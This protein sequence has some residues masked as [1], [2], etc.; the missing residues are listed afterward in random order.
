M[1]PSFTFQVTAYAFDHWMAPK[2]VFTITVTRAPRRRG[3]NGKCFIGM[4]VG[5]YN[6]LFG[7]RQF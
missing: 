2:A 5:N 1:Q 7:G 4:F 6:V 3:L